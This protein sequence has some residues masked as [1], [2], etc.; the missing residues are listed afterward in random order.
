MTSPLNEG[1]KGKVYTKMS[2]FTEAVLLPGKLAVFLFLPGNLQALQGRLLLYPPLQ[3][4]LMEAGSIHIT[5][6]E[7]SLMDPLLVHRVQKHCVWPHM[8]T[9]TCRAQTHTHAHAHAH[10]YTHAH[11]PA[12]QHTLSHS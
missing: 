9:Y 11:T 2:R 8:H 3:P 12:L 1:V 7:L 10:T 4:H 6:Y 5:E